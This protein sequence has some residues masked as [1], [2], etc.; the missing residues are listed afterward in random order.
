MNVLLQYLFLIQ[1][2]MNLDNVVF[3]HLALDHKSLKIDAFVYALV[4]VNQFPACDVSRS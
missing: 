3:V 4:M 2:S 1:D